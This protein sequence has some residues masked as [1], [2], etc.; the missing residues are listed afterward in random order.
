MKADLEG[1]TKT[2]TKAENV[3]TPAPVEA[4]APEPEP[5][6]EPAKEEPEQDQPKPFAHEPPKDWARPKD[7]TETE[8]D[9]EQP[10]TEH[11]DIPDDPLKRAEYSFKRQL[12][13]KD[14]KHAEELA[15]RDKENA[16]LKARLAALEKKM[17]PENKPKTRADFPDDEEFMDYKVDR[18]FNAKMAEFQA[19]KEKQEAERAEQERQKAEAEQRLREQQESWLANVDQAFA[20]DANRSKAF[21]ENVAYANKHGL[22]EV[23]DNCPVA[24]DYLINDPYG[25][26]VFEKLL[27][28]QS[29]F[30]RVFD[31]RRPSPLAIYH[32]LRAV[33]DEI[34]HAPAPS[35]EPAPA[36][37]VP[38]MGRPGK[39][40]GGMSVTNNDMWSDPKAIKKWLREHR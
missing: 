27:T 13:K 14:K 11:R 40:A 39:Q 38:K 16:E 10:K 28:D 9:Q 31:P 12:E 26:L 7:E 17:D 24:S 6:P 37:V 8:Q 3:E 4:P 18:R 25:P 20:G 35:P 23:L 36:P 29:T 2:E 32:E 33:E 15:A 30:N 1:E 34:R 5:E 19:E 21:L 22:G